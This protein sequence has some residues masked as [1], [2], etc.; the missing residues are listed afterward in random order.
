MRNYVGDSLDWDVNLILAGEEVPRASLGKTARLGH[1]CW[2]GT[3][4]DPDDTRPDAEDLFLYPT[5]GQPE[6]AA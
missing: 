3:R 6:Q 4:Q 1:V 2:M 5:L